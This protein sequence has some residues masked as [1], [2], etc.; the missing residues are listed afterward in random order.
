MELLQANTFFKDLKSK[1]DGDLHYDNL[2]KAIYATDASVYRKIPQAVAYPKSINDIKHLIKFSKKNKTSLIPRTAGTSLAGQCVGNGIVVDV[3]KH[4]TKILHLDKKAKTI[5]VE[6][7]VIR[8]ELNNYLKPYGLFFGPNTSTSNRCMI[9][10]MV[11]NNSSGTTSIQYGVTRDK[12]LELKTILSDATEVVFGEITK[13]EFHEKIKLNSLEGSVYKALYEELSLETVQNEILEQF[14]KPEIH[15]RNTGYAIDELI[16]TDVFSDSSEKFNMCKLLSGSEGTLAFTTEI[17]LQLDVLPPKESLMVAPHFN[18][19]QDCLSAVETVMQHDLHIC[20]MM[21]KTILDLTK[22]NK[23]QEE[24]RQFIEGDPQAILMC[25][26]KGDTLNEVQLKAENLI[27]AI[28]G[29]NLSFSN[30]ILKT[31]D[32]DKAIELR[33]AGLGLLGNMIGDR[34]TAACI[35]DTAVALPDL[36]SY[37]SEFT[38]LMTKYN[39]EAVYYAHAGAGELHLRPILNLKK[40]EDVVLFRK[41]TTEVAH[42]VKK[43]KGSMSGEHGDGIVRAE[44]I[45]LMIGESNYQI[46]KRI[47][48]AFDPDSIFNPGK[49]VNAFPMDESLRYVPNREEPKI[50]TFLDF[51]DSLGILREAEKCN[52]SGDCR[53]LPEF[54]GTMCP[55]YRATRNEKD[56]TRAR[57][58]ALR[59]FLTN[60]EKENKFNHKG[61]K[62]VFDLCLSCK[63]C[64]SECPSSVDVASLK[65]EFLYQYQQENG[66]SLRTKLFAYN[67]HLN[68]L[69]S[70]FSGFTNFMFSNGFTSSILK[71]SFGIASKRSLP[72]ISTK[73]L[74]KHYKNTINKEDRL[75]YIKTVYLF[76]DEFTNHL[77]TQI[78]IDALVLLKALNYKAIILNHM[79]SGRSFL[80]KG[81]LKQA[82][83]VANKNIEIFKDRITANTPLIGIEP[84]AILSFKDEYLKLAEDKTSAKSIAKHCFLIEE[85]LQQEIILGN[86]KAEQF[87]K[88]AQIIKFHGH[89]HQK[90]LSNQKTSFDVLNLPENYE[91]TIIPSGCCGMAGSFGY[92]KEHY[93]V[94]M[95]IGEQ[96]LFPAIRKASLETIISANGTSCRHQIK[97]GTQVETKH[98]VTILKEALL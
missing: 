76:N 37:I 83:K 69:G 12:V 64:A 65:A 50:E 23:T 72:L 81:L 67:N 18:S 30:P 93:E 49:I 51:S 70:R 85:F 52:G 55:S 95:K 87:T 33:K 10:G 38:K 56:T 2:T 48:A 45:P 59:E 60:S 71:K 68:E 32:I 74:I 27:N 15:R 20:E 91:V 82:K 57:A 47:K 44:F 84:S 21:D 28:E 42:L 4:F 73:S 90:A 14:P 80:S 54:G 31:D 92:E 97:D 53:K 17:T 94:S 26:I 62:E 77:D 35:E 7:G 16:K 36:A 25:E 43:Y 22:H 88:E 86:I 24:N 98:P 9:G 3:S 5:T 96:T 63:A 1:L 41:I 46:L 61:L 75:K 34:K 78:G 39:Q 79:E 40:K 89:C 19:I 66:V 58:N 8:D 29:L 6:P 13:N 11:G